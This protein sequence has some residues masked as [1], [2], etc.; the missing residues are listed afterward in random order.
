MPTD[1]NAILARDRMTTQPS[2]STSPDRGI[3]RL[4]ANHRNFLSF[5]A[6]RVGSRVA[7]E[8]ILRD[9]VVRGVQKAS[10]IPALRRRARPMSACQSELRRCGRC[11]MRCFARVPSKL[12]IAALVAAT[13]LLACTVQTA[14][15]EPVC[16][17][18]VPIAVLVHGRV[19]G[20]TFRV[21]PGL[22]VTCRHVLPAH[23]TS[24][25]VDGTRREIVRRCD[26][27]GIG[28]DWSVLEL[29]RPELDPFATALVVGAT[30]GEGEE[31]WT[32]GFPDG[33]THA[34]PHVIHG[35]LQGNLTGL[36]G[37]RRLDG[38]GAVALPGMSG[39]PVV[40]RGRSGEPQVVGVLHGHVEIG[41]SWAGL[42]T[43]TSLAS[44]VVAQRDLRDAVERYLGSA[45]P[46]KPGE[47][48]PSMD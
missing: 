44:A 32:A 11:A 31:V 41:T 36:G 27:R 28:G 24:C 33:I 15:V 20:T 25:E 30:V 5:L 17:R 1:N 13:G 43:T 48:S 47:V 42:I 22:W 40:R 26:G 3:V 8:E 14:R 35:R 21:G 9:A 39:A 34:G 45:V 2:D 12:A 18:E 19:A 37:M 4:L 29:A 10:D 16:F 7:A 6:A 46:T 23:A 38:G